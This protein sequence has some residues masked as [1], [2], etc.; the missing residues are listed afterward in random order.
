M[1]IFVSFCLSLFFSNISFSHARRRIFVTITSDVAFSL[2][3]FAEKLFL[4]CLHT[5]ENKT[6]K[7]C[8]EF[9]VSECAD[10]AS[11]T[12]TWFNYAVCIFNAVDVLS[13]YIRGCCEMIWGGWKNWRKLFMIIIKGWE[14]YSKIIF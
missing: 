12:Y 7:N 4:S 6:S 10:D 13:F 11:A 1:S 5:K 3:L 9:V 2:Q 14:F 8:F